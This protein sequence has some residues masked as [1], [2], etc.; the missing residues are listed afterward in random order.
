MPDIIAQAI[1]FGNRPEHGGADFTLTIATSDGVTRNVAV[2]V[3]EGGH[4]LIGDGA[5]ADVFINPAH[6]VSII[7]EW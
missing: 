7:V 6:V 1:A 3:D 5:A 2:V 4:R